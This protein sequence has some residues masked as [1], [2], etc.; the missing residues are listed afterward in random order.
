M[1]VLFKIFPNTCDCDK[2][3]HFFITK[4]IALPTANMKEGK[5]KSVGVKPCY[6]AWFNGAYAVALLPGVFTIIIKQTV[7]PRNTW[8]TVRATALQEDGL[9]AR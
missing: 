1:I 2:L 5:T 8:I 7:M 9:A 6:A 3:F 4:L